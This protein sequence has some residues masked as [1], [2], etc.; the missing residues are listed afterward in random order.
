M[1]FDNGDPTEID[2]FE[3]NFCSIDHR[4]TEEWAKEH[5]TESYDDQ[6]IRALF[7]LPK[8]GNFQVL[9][10]GTIS[11]FN[12]EIGEECD[13]DFIVIESKFQIIPEIDED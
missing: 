1:I 11:V 7:S 10:K 13:E 12:Y 6:Q 3:Y 5:L 4:T 2:V 9:F 8:E